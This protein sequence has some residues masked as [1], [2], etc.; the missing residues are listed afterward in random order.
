MPVTDSSSPEKQPMDS[1]VHTVT[2]L[3]SSIETLRSTTVNGHSIGMVSLLRVL[4]A[5]RL[6]LQQTTVEPILSDLPS[7]TPAVGVFAETFSPQSSSSSRHPGTNNLPAELLF[8]IFKL[9]LDDE[10]F[11]SLDLEWY[12][13]DAL[14]PTLFPFA[15]AA[16]CSLWRDIVSLV[17]N[18]WKRIVISSTHRSLRRQRSLPSFYGLAIYPST[19]S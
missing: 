9:A 2:W 1:T 6:T 17:P 18:Y 11:R 3:S 8:V 14:S 4:V 16:V 13:F 15:V 10:R 5:V 12:K 7:D 19:S